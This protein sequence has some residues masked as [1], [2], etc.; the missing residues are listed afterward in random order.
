MVLEHES[1]I[2]QYGIVWSWTDVKGVKIK[3]NL[4]EYIFQ[5]CVQTKRI[6]SYVRRVKDKPRLAIHQSTSRPY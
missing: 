5:R 3:A 1:E 2:R 6:N 4:V